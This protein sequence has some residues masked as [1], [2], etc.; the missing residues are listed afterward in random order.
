M[1]HCCTSMDYHASFSCEVHSEPEA[2]PD[3]LVSYSEKFREYG[4]WIH[5]GG[6]SSI[7]IAFCPWCGS[8]LPESLRERWFVELEALGFDDPFGQEIPHRFKSGAW[9]A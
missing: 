6:S 5:D 3:A 9:Y 7:S 8:E 1:K 4:L 2:C